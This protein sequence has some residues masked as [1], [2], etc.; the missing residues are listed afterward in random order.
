MTDSLTYRSAGTVG[1]IGRS[2]GFTAGTTPHPE[3]TTGPERWP[4]TDWAT[5]P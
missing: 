3:A 5:S 1:T 2:G 4:T